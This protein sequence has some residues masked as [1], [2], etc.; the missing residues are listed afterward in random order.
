MIVALN[1][2]AAGKRLQ[3]GKPCA[4]CGATARDMCSEHYRMV[5]EALT[6]I[7]TGDGIYGAQAREYKNI[8][9]KALGMEEV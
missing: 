9:R 8:A 4:H 7:A 2:C 6:S 1:T 5:C 3:P